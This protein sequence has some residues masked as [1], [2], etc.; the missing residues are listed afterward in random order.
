MN[1]WLLFL[2]LILSIVA[3]LVAQEK[4]PYRLGIERF[5]PAMLQRVTGKASARVGLITNQS[6]KTQNGTRSIDLLLKKGVNVVTIFAPEH[7]INGTIAAGSNVDDS[8][9]KATQLPIASLY[10]LNKKNNAISYEDTLDA[11]VFDIQDVG[12]RHYTYSATLIAVLE[13]A[14]AQNLPLIVLDRPNPLGI[15]MEGPL[16]TVKNS[17]LASV[18]IPLRHA[19]TMGEIARYC[20]K[21]VLAKPAQLHVVPLAN[22]TRNYSLTKLLAPLSPNIQ[23]IQACYG[24]SFLGLLGEIQPFDVGIG[25]KEAFHLAGLPAA[26]LSKKQNE[27][28]VTLLKN[29]GVHAEAIDYYNQRKK[30]HYRGAKITHISINSFSAFNTFLS[31]LNFCK[32]QNIPFAFSKDFDAALGSSIVRDYMS[33]RC[34]FEELQKK[35]NTDLKAFY[36]KAQSVFIYEPLPKMILV[37]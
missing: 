15:I 25:T 7:G 24:Y 13:V 8:V 21:Y 5:S 29:K 36:A 31:I 28:F 11:F 10:T 27:L 22:Y 9:D 32:K 18:P 14:A 6:G 35:I 4:P 16:A 26:L 30:K 37:E 2:A 33:G 3:N 20:N 19:M 23:N 34:S 12:M 1:K 17:F